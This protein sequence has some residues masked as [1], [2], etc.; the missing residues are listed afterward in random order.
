MGIDP[1]ITKR[2]WNE[3]YVLNWVATETYGKPNASY[4]HCIRN[5]WTPARRNDLDGELAKYD[6]GN[7]PPDSP[8]TNG[9]L[10]LHF[11]ERH[12]YEKAKQV[13][14]S[15]AAAPLGKIQQFVKG[16]M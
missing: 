13:E 1:E 7:G 12:K 5:G 2:L 16:E 3:G 14:K 11:I 6:K 9:G 8:I 10:V 4:T 15:K